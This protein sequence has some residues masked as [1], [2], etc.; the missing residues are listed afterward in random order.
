MIKEHRSY[1]LCFCLKIKERIW[2]AGQ[3]FPCYFFIDKRDWKRIKFLSFV[4]LSFC[5]NP[6]QFHFYSW[7]SSVCEQYFFK[8]LKQDLVSLRPFCL[9]GYFLFLD[10][11]LLNPSGNEVM[12]PSLV[13]K[14]SQR[15][16]ESHEFT[17]TDST[18]IKHFISVY[19]LLFVSLLDC[20]SGLTLWLFLVQDY[21]LESS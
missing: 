13:S 15:V 18:F 3:S 6:S 4:F 9:F 7:I 21:F 12:K 20:D 5:R 1:F 17:D 14:S 8:R 16:S 19:P 2:N 10:P 11:L